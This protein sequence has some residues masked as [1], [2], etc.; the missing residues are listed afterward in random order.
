[1]IIF[2]NVLYKAPEIA[3]PG[4]VAPGILLLGWLLLTFSLYRT[5]LGETGYFVHPLCNLRDTCHA[6]GYQV[7]PTQPLPRE[8]ED[9]PSVDRYFKHVPP[10]T[11]LIYLSPK[12]V[13]MTGFIYTL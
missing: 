1:M 4:M 7:L 9:F 13:Y 8:V 12:G 11:Y 3:A 5:P 2:S 10:L 6:T